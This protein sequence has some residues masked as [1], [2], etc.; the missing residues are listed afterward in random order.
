MILEE[1]QALHEYRK[2]Q[3]RLLEEE[4][5]LKK[6]RLVSSHS[7]SNVKLL[8]A[9]TKHNQT[10]LLLGAVIKRQTSLSEIKEA[11]KE[12]PPTKKAKE[13]NEDSSTCSSSV[14]ALSALGDYD[15]DSEDECN[16]G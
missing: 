15:S 4:E 14:N 16:K 1:K 5:E 12:E 9:N 6:K 8:G 11:H 2:S 13:K 10:K 7:A 3:D